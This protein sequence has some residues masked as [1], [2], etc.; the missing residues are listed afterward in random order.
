MNKLVNVVLL[1]TL[2]WM[3]VLQAAPAGGE[4]ATDGTSVEHSVEAPPDQPDEGWSGFSIF[5]LVFTVSVLFVLSTATALNRMGGGGGKPP[6]GRPRKP[7]T[8]AK[9]SSL[10]KDRERFRL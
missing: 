7:T 5:L 3:P 2:L 1:C 8:T 9:R 4:V 6:T 10:P